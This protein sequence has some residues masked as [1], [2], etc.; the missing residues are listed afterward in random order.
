MKKRGNTKKNKRVLKGGGFSLKN[1]FAKK[2]NTTGIFDIDLNAAFRFNKTLISDEMKTKTSNMVASTSVAM[3]DFGAKASATMQDV[4]AKTTVAMKDFG[5]KASATMQDVGAKAT[6]T[7]QDIGAKASATMQDVGAKANNA[8]TNL[9]G[10]ANQTEPIPVVDE[11]KDTNMPETVVN[12]TNITESEE[13]LKP[14]Q[15]GGA[16][17]YRKLFDTNNLVEKSQFENTNNFI[18]FLSFIKQKQEGGYELPEEFISTIDSGK[19]YKDYSSPHLLFYITNNDYKGCLFYDLHKTVMNISSIFNIL[20]DVS[21]TLND[22]VIKIITN[23]PIL[24]TIKINNTN[25]NLIEKMKTNDSFKNSDENV[26]GYTL[27]VT[28][29]AEEPKSSFFK[30][31]FAK[32]QDITPTTEEVVVSPIKEELALVNPE[33]DKIAQVKNALDIAITSIGK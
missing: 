9:K 15:S 21:D 12:E 31:P 7:M 25:T 33:T 26:E 19:P 18:K 30:N 2:V 20:D 10:I 4:G 32:K 6:A 29:K 5:A 16:V 27:F 11:N 17:T 14:V 1:P 13:K 3:K 8:I 28:T 24:K 22:E 23:T